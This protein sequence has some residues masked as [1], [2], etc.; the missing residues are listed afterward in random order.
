MG[1]R[2]AEEMEIIEGEVVAIQ[3]DTLLDK[4]KREKSG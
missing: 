1:V 4:T 2:I 3:V